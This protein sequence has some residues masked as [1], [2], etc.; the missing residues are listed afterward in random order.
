MS[1]VE[2]MPPRHPPPTRIYDFFPPLRIIKRIKDWW[3][4]VFRD[5]VHQDD[6]VKGGK[7]KRKGAFKSEIPQEI[8]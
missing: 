1:T 4:S 3:L 5:V 7:R 6:R 8:L 2:L